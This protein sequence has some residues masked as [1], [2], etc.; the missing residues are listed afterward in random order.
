LGTQQSLAWQFAVLHVM[1]A[2]FATN[3]FI[4]AVQSFPL[5]VQVGLGTQQSLA[6]HFLSSAHFFFS[7]S[8]MKVVLPCVQRLSWLVHLE[9]SAQQSLA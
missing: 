9:A 7:G 5:P 2:E 6:V 4:P 8:T 3:V 1:L